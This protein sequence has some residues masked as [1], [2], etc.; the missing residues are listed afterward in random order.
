M[1]QVKKYKVTNLSTKAENIIDK[2]DFQQ[3]WPETYE[4][5]TKN[6]ISVVVRDKDRVSYGFKFEKISID[7]PECQNCGAVAIVEVCGKTSDCCAMQHLHRS[8]DGYVLRGMG[9]GADDYL[10]FHFCVNCGQIQGDFPKR[11]HGALV[12]RDTEGYPYA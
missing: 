3:I 4:L 11:I 6:V 9:V 10:E 8:Y 1:V 12:T 7:L 2:K 5:M